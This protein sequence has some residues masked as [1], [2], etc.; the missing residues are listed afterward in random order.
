MGTGSYNTTVAGGKAIS[1]TMWTSPAIFDKSRQVYSKLVTSL[2]YQVLQ[3]YPKGGMYGAW[4][5]HSQCL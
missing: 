5:F 3:L 4:V 2:I 1:S